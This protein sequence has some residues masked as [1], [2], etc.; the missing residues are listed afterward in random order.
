MEAPTAPAATPIF[1][2]KLHHG[3]GGSVFERYWMGGNLATP[4]PVPS[5]AFNETTGTPHGITSEARLSTDRSQVLFNFGDSTGAVI[6]I[7]AVPPS[8]A[9]TVIVATAV[10]GQ[11]IGFA[12]WNGAACTKVVYARSNP[13]TGIAYAEIRI[14][15]ADGTGDTLLY[16][17][18]GSLSGEFMYVN[19]ESL[20][21]NHAGTKIAWVDQCQSVGGFTNA[22]IYVMNIDGSSV[23]RIV[24]WSAADFTTSDRLI[25]FS[26]DDTYLAY[27]Q[28]FGGNVHTRK[29]TMGGTITDLLTSAVYFRNQYDFQWFPDDS[30]V[31]GIHANVY[32][33]QP[34][35]VI[36]KIAADG[37]GVT[38]LSPERRIDTS[39]A[40]TT[41]KNYPVVWDHDNRIYWYDLASDSIVSVAADGSDFRTDHTLD[42]TNLDV[43]NDQDFRTVF[44]GS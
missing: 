18:G 36:E 37:S 1:L 43:L 33:T 21:V 41:P 30:G 5:T 24:D 44:S 39:G 3:V 40:I 31:L 42:A 19:I 16:N 28:T 23:T 8:V 22:G 13:S 34:R 10:S 29:V 2:Y 17:R 25:G 6:R 20:L 38:A 15:N 4:I 7:G 12:C 27:T 35:S 32:G 11:P 9:S 26:H 14:V